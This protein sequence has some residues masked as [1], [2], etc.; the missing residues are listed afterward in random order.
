MM[1]A[2]VLTVMV[3]VITIALAMPLGRYLHRVYSDEL[4]WARQIL[5]QLK[6]SCTRRLEFVRQRKWTGSV[7]PLPS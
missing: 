1:H 2:I 7:M 3:L 6:I 4:F 5:V